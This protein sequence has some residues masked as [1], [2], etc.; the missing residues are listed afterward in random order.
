M[1]PT[2]FT[3]I[4]LPSKTTDSLETED[5]ETLQGWPS[6]FAVIGNWMGRLDA[7][8]RIQPFHARTMPPPF[9]CYN[10]SPLGGRKPAPEPCYGVG[11]IQMF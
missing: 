3:N 2:A 5:G 11:G 6:S 7:V 8:R 4:I 10:L 1:C 9:P